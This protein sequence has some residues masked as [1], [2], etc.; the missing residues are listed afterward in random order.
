MN[1]EEWGKKYPI[2]AIWEGRIPDLGI[3]YVTSIDFRNNRI[4]LSNG[5]IETSTE[6]SNVKIITRFLSQDK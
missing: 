3:C 2:K 1:K 6:L 4:S 5:Q